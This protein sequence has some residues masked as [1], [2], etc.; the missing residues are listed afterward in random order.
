MSRTAIVTLGVLAAS[1]SHTRAREMTVNEHESEAARHEEAARRDREQFEP[2]AT[3]Q[4]P[5]RGPFV[6][7]P[8]N[9]MSAYNPST[10]HLVAA[11]AQMRKATEHL[12]AARQLERFEA[13]ACKD[14]APAARAACPLLA[15]SVSR[16]GHTERGVELEL[17]PGADVEGTVR[18]LNCHLAYAEANGF[19]K[20]SCPLFVRGMTIRQRGDRIVEL[21]GSSTE[22]AAELQTQ[23]SRVFTGAPIPTLKK[24]P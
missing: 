19:E 20:P 5:G 1:C 8:S 12:A 18:R 21:R 13:D 14:I 16:V 15:S 2:G 22:V 11:D 17:K 24:S 6:D 3:N 23:S 4:V 10:E 7:S 9:W